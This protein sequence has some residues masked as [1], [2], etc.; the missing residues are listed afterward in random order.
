MFV[1]HTCTYMT[2]YSVDVHLLVLGMLLT[3]VIILAERHY[4][5][6]ILR[7]QLK[8]LEVHVYVAQNNKKKHGIVQLP[9]K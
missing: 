4:R 2:L 8:G 9:Q 3:P 6:A 5:V 7:R 1:W